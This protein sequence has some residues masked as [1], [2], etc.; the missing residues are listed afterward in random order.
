MNPDLHR[1][2]FNQDKAFCNLLINLLIFEA[3]SFLL[4]AL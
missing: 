4:P 3:D 2:K 1:M